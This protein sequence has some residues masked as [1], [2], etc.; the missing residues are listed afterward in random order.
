MEVDI[1]ERKLAEIRLRESEARWQFA[2]EGAGDGVWDWNVPLGRVDYSP[3]WKEMLGHGPEEIGSS[4]EEWKQRVH[5]DDLAATLDAVAR[6]LRG[7]TE[8][9]VSEHR[10]RCKD[11]SYLWV[12][13]RGKVMERDAAGNALRLVGTHTDMTRRKLA[14]QRLAESERRFRMLSDS[15][16]VLIWM[17]DAEGRPNFVNKVWEDF[18]G[19]SEAHMTESGWA[20]VVHPDDAPLVADHFAEALAR[21]QPFDLEFRM[22]RA[23]GVFRWVRDGGVPRFDG[24]GA[25]LGF[26]GSAFDVTERREAEDALRRSRDSLQLQVLEQTADLRQAKEA[27]ERASEAKS[28]FLAN[29]SHELR[30]PMHAI[31]SFA[32]IGTNR[33]GSASQDKLAEYF[34]RIR[35][36]GERLLLLV[37]DLLDLSR[38]EAGRTVM[39][40]GACDLA[41]LVEEV[42]AEFEP[43]LAGKALSFDLRRGS[44]LPAVHG[45]PAQL[46]RVIRNLLSNAIKFSPAGRRIR[47]VL[48][49][50]RLP[51][52]RRAGDSGHSAA[53]ELTV[54]DQGVGIPEA[55]LESVFDKFVQSSK[56]RSGAGGTGLGLAICREIVNAH[57]GR[58]FA[59]NNAEGGAD[60]VMR[61]PALALPQTQAIAET[62]TSP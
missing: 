57:R 36:S 5:P 23:D 49:A 44:D 45:D 37:N 33:L 29:M 8:C 28:R 13:D 12:L 51:A 31:L 25:F 26:V 35:V 21:R 7:E 2:L 11:G 58:I 53:V 4:L 59:R 34:D 15:A 60:F 32:R 61:L 27:A 3:R 16:P 14:E 17:C 20:R 6:H 50:A 1:T 55:E 47:V 48:A 40:H 38:L 9:Y 19:T 54:S 52:G 10:L 62:E 22:R 39:E 42:H 56:T 41:A 30:T 18:T 24:E 43:L 46:G